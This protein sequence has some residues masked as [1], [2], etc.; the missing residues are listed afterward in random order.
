MNQTTKK[1]SNLRR[2]E[3]IGTAQAREYPSRR[4][5]HTPLQ[6]LQSMFSS[7][8]H[9]HHTNTQSHEHEQM[10]MITKKPTANVRRSSSAR[11]TT[12]SLVKD[13]L[14]DRKKQHHIPEQHSDTTAII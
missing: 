2:R 11:E 6:Q 9:S 1:I 10:P 5:H 8:R 7:I 4:Q 13:R 3:T 12:Q 14:N